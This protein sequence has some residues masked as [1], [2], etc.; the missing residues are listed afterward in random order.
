MENK[1]NL[2]SLITKWKPKVICI[3]ETIISGID[4]KLI[5]FC[6]PN[7]H[8]SWM[9]QP[10]SGH[11][12]GLLTVWKKE[13]FDL[14]NAELRENWV[15]V[16]LQFRNGG[17]VFNLFNVYAP[18]GTQEK[19]AMWQ[20][21]R[22]IDALLDSSPTI[23]IGDFNEVRF[24]RERTN[25]NIRPREM[26]E[27]NS[28]IEDSNLLEIPLENANFTWIGPNGKRSTLDRA[29]SNSEWPN[30]ADWTLKA[31]S[32]KNSDHRGI[33]LR[34]KQQ[35]WGPKPFRAFNVWL[36]N[37]SLNKELE[38][39]FSKSSGLTNHHLQQKLR[40]VKHVIK[41]WNL[42]MNGN[43]FQRISEMEDKFAKL[44][45][46]NGPRNELTILKMSMEEL[47]L[48]RDSMLKQKARVEWLKEGDRN[49]KFFNQAIQKIRVRN[50]IKK[51][52][53]KR[54]LSSDPLEIKQEAKAHFQ[55]VFRKEKNSTSLVL[56]ASFLKKYQNWRSI[57]EVDTTP[58]SPNSGITLQQFIDQRRKE[59]QQKLSD[60]KIKM[61]GLPIKSL[62]NYS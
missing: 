5:N 51:L 2:R 6:W 27:F 18:H 58:H 8:L 36:R 25:C 54:R 56:K 10:P 40:N 12:G 42:S 31:L 32:R 15:G 37:S 33:L 39:H 30:L 11:S 44:D 29:L 20:D 22:R 38:E 53:C 19:L 14:I 46:E 9:F 3:Q 59:K 17:C 57:E 13:E 41:T 45:E 55:Q 16:S 26:R 49:S 23:F 52:L 47:C 61:A 34:A 28:W 7:E 60:S 1:K 4:E 24:Q 50:L 43:I 21:F 48:I 62:K 35:N